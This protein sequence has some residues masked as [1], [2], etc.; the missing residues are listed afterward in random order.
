MYTDAIETM[1]A[2][3]AAKLDFLK[4]NP[5]GYFTASMMAGVFI[6]FGSFVAMTAGGYCTPLLGGM[7]K[8]A[9]AIAFASAL[10]LVVM[11]GAELFTGNNMV[12]GLGAL[13]K[14]TSWRSCAWLWTV[15]WLG[16]FAGSWLALLAYHFSGADVLPKNPEVP[17]FFLAVAAAKCGLGPLALVI[18]GILCNML[19]CLGVWCG[20]KMKS[21]SGKLIM[22]SW[23]ILIFMLCGF[24]HAI[25][26]MSIIGAALFNPA[27]A[28]KGVT[29]GA[30][31]FN[32]G[33]A[34]VGNILG[35]LVFVALPYLVM[36]GRKD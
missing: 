33:W 27:A 7:A 16:N 17:Q 14:R 4:K 13:M 5:L 15:C 20:L 1:A 22:I 3:S 34:T 26:N 11:A 35:G 9:P 30:Y 2:A 12:V 21:E 29:I 10:S 23:C 6:S 36:A 8:I 31:F 25:A 28:E 19:V 32:L 24:E 18:R